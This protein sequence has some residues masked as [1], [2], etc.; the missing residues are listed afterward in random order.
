MKLVRRSFLLLFVALPLTAAVKVVGRGVSLASCDG[1][2]DSRQLCATSPCGRVTVPFASL[3]QSHDVVA[4]AGGQWEITTESSRCFAP[5]VIVDASSSSDLPVWPAAEIHGTIESKLNHTQLRAEFRLPAVGHEEHPQRFSAACEAN[6]TRWS[7]RMP[8][9]R[10]ELRLELEHHAP[11]YISLTLEPGETRDFGV[12]RFEPGGSVAGRITPAERHEETVVELKRES[13]GPSSIPTTKQP[14]RRVVL[15]KSSDGFFQ[16]TGVSPGNYHLTAS[17]PGWSSADV[18]ALRL[19]RDTE[20]FLEAPVMLKRR[21]VIDVFISPPLSL[22]GEPWIVRLDQGTGLAPDKPLAESA[23]SFSGEWRNEVPA[24]GKYALSV[25]DRSGARFLQVTV[26]ASMQPSAR[27]LT[28]DKIHVR[29]VVMLGAMPFPSRLIFTDNEG[30]ANITLR[31]GTTGTFDGILPHDGQWNVQVW[32]VT[33]TYYIRAVEVKLKRA[34]DQD[35]AEVV[36]ELPGGKAKGLVTDETGKPGKG[37]VM[38]FQGG[39]IVADALVMPDGSFEV[40]GLDPGQ[41][42]LQA[43][44]RSA[45]SEFTA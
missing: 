31:T 37:D 36:V 29:G 14:F 32:N 28:I 23:A 16:F 8:A 2:V 15:R 27:F 35:L 19:D 34:P 25:I 12:V 40:S 6:E 3:A 5:T 41:T 38:I 7:C 43:Y 13:E 26:E 20:I 24:P 4:L 9:G 17:R 44:A 1:T 33:D 18:K 21:S 39:R 11:R 42:R 10:L 30:S 22:D 45:E